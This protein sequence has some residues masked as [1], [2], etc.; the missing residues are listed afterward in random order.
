MPGE[1]AL[2]T[3][4]TFLA[5]GLVPLGMVCS[6]GP[7]MI[8]LVSRSIA[9]RRKAGL[10]S[11][12]GV[13]AGFFGYLLL[14][15]LG[16]AAVLVAVPPAYAALKWAGAA[17]LLWLAWQAVRPGAAPLFETRDLPHDSPRR[18]FTMGLLTNLLN[19]KIA[20]LYVSLLPQ[21]VDP[22]R[23]AVLAQSLALGLTQI[24]VSLAVNTC[25]FLGA[26]SLALMLARRP[27]WSKFQRWFMATVLG[28]LAVRRHRT[29]GALTS[30]S[31]GPAYLPIRVRE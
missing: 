18:L 10:V 31:A 9:Q 22:E 30:A 6:P 11:L 13:A 27:I 15:C 17:Y 12:L 8:Y 2:P 14:T 19:P 25:I 7:N 4:N 3:P 16:L 5:F 24:T 26:G 20:V 21:F 28:L 1:E 23:G 29:P